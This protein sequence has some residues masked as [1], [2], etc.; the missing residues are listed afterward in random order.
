MRDISAA[1]EQLVEFDRAELET[2]LHPG[3]LITKKGKR[4]QAAYIRTAPVVYK[5]TKLT[6]EQTELADQIDQTAQKGRTSRENH[7][8]RKWLSTAS[9][10]SEL[11]FSCFEGFFDSSIVI[12]KKK[13]Q[14]GLPL[15]EKWTE[16]GA[17]LA[18]KNN[19][20]AIAYFSHTASIVTSTF[21]NTDISTF[22][23][24]P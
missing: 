12:L 19:R 21:L 24:I 2:V 6:T 18:E 16:I 11:S 4:V 3:K 13:G 22:T 20:L 9:K 8:F 7:D 1:A 17:S 23:A 15:L 14:K 10:A 5:L